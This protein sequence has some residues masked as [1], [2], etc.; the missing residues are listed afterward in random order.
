VANDSKP[1]KHYILGLLT[2]LL[3]SCNQSPS[4]DSM[5]VSG[6]VK[7]LKKGTLYLQHIP[8]STLVTIDS[9]E[10]DGSGNFKFDTKIESPEVFYL[11]LNK[12]DNNTINDRITFF[13]ELGLIEINTK[14]NTFDID[15]VVKGTKSNEKFIEYREMMSKFNIQDMTYMENA[16]RANNENNQLVLDSLQNASEKNAL[17]R[18]LFVLNFALNNADSYVAPYV[19]LNDVPNANVKFLDSIYNKLSPEVTNSKYGKELDLFIKE[20]KSNN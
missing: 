1:M 19:T 14:W 7:G 9:I 6:Q 18:Y 3:I 10:I 11:Y 15:P 16:F 4:M 12:K 17:R 5:I 20:I 8:D 2:I 13:G